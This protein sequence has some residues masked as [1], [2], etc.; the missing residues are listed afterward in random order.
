MTRYDVVVIGAGIHGAGVAQAAAAAGYSVLVLEQTAPASGT[1]SRS[2]KLIHGGLRYLESAQWRLVRAALHERAQLLRLAPELVRLTPF[3]IPIYRDTRRQALSIVAGLSLYAALGRFAR[4]TGFTRVPRARWDRLDGLTTHQLLHVF[5]YYDAQT[6]DAALTRAVLRSAQNLG[7]ELRCPAQFV[8]AERTQAGYAVHYGDAARAH[9]CE[10]AALINAA[11]PW[12]MQ[13]NRDIA[14]EPP[15]PAVEL[16]QGTHIVLPQQLAHGC[17][18]LEAAD[19]RAVFA[20]PW[21][22]QAL[23]GTTETPYRGAPAAVQPLAQEVEYLLATAR[24]Y[25]PNIA[26]QASASFAGLRVLPRGA[27]APFARA[28]ETVLGA[29]VATRPRLVGI[30]GG[31]LT[32]YRLTALQTMARLQAALPTRTRRARTADLPLSPA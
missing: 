15:A 13:V 26:A 9:T 21:K 3:H 29:D 25:F 4:N 19:R 10:C 20:L 31:K 28:R 11:G 27:D 17:Y 32:T 16:V 12:A 1:S 7:A 2:S 22:G 8:R 18:Y 30:Y 14:P 24:R 5:R 23:I 6:D